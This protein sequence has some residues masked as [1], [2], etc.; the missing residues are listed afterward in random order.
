MNLNILPFFILF[1]ASFVLCKSTLP[2]DTIVC[3]NYFTSE[4]CNNYNSYDCFWCNSTSSCGNCNP[5][6]SE[7]TTNNLVCPDDNFQCYNVSKCVASEIF[8]SITLVLIIL[9]FICCL[10]Y[11]ALKIDS[12][13]NV[14]LAIPVAFLR[15]LSI[16]GG[17]I[18]IYCVVSLI[19]SFFVY[20]HNYEIFELSVQIMCGYIAII[21]IF[22]IF[23]CLISLLL[24]LTIF[25]YERFK[26]FEKDTT[27]YHAYE[28]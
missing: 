1:L 4:N 13:K 20:S 26:C 23:V 24:S 7:L 2:S 6:T 18:V 16:I 14:C 11:C 8:A 22:G 12:S 9:L 10:L 3:S 21:S 5:C 28:L 19:I 25:L 27:E 17:I 15:I